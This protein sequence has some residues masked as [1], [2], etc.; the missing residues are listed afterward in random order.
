[1]SLIKLANALTRNWHLLSDAEK[2]IAGKAGM[3]KS[4]R[5]YILGHIKGNQ[6]ILKPYKNKIK[7]INNDNYTPGYTTNLKYGKQEINQVH[8]GADFLKEH[9]L[10]PSLK[11]NQRHMTDAIAYRHETREGIAGYNRYKNY[12]KY[13]KTKFNKNITDVTHFMSSKNKPEFTQEMFQSLVKLNTLP[14]FSSSSYAG[15]MNTSIPLKDMLDMQ[16]IPHK[17]LISAMINMREKVGDSQALRGLKVF[18]KSDMNRLVQTPEGTKQ[19]TRAM[20]NA[21]T[22]FHRSD[23]KK[24]KNNWS[25]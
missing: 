8:K 2:I 25:R 18:S 10:L 6:N 5:K 12:S 21:D 1:M 7:F 24:I 15:H 11:G 20:T 9:N 13:N 19:V 14:N 22:R 16:K 23:I 17:S 3:V 4:Q